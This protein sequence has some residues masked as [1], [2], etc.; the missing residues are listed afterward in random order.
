MDMLRY[1]VFIV[2]PF[3][4]FEG[5]KKLLNKI[6]IREKIRLDLKNTDINDF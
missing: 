5:K 2:K 3:S 6:K 4:K 1:I